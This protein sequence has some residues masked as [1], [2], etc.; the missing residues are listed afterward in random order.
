MNRH[1]IGSLVELTIDEQ[2]Y[3]QWVTSGTSLA[4]GNPPLLHFG[5]GKAE[6]IDTIQV[7]W[8]TGESTSISDVDINNVNYTIN[9]IDIK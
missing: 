8:P 5:L 1:G 4:S 9:N 6:N 2:Q 3:T 7:Y